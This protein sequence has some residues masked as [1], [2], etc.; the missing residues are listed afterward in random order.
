G[1]AHIAMRDARLATV[2]ATHPQPTFRPHTDYYRELVESIISQQLSVKAASTIYKRFIDSFGHIPEPAEILARDETELRAVGLSGQKSRYIKDL[3]DKVLSGD[4]RFDHLD[5]LTNETIVAELTAVKG[6]GEWTVHMFL[7][8]CMG[9][10]DVLP[11]GDLGIKNA[12]QKLYSLETQPTP[13]D[14]RRIADEN[15]WNPYRSVASWYLW[16]S[17]ENSP[18]PPKTR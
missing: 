4:V 1:I 5:Q 12:V 14:I 8:F 9:R 16:Q 2:I 18:K 10:F 6:V 15:E 17:L 13:A 7:M 3:A 11:V